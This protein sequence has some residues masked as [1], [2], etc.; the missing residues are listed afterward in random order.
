M[1][2]LFENLLFQFPPMGCQ[3]YRSQPMRGQRS[4]ITAKNTH[5]RCNRVDQ[6]KKLTVRGL[7]GGGKEG[8][9]GRSWVQGRL[10]VLGIHIHMY[11]IN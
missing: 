5:V 8:F 1:P 9:V 11:A 10:F 2:V 3:H 4:D 6:A 7:Q